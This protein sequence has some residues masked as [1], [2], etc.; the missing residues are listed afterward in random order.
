MDAA[1]PVTARLGGIASGAR[2]GPS[3]RAA[4]PAKGSGS[5][6]RPPA[7]LYVPGARR[8]NQRADKGQL[9]EESTALF[10]LEV[11][12]SAGIE[13]RSKGASIG[14]RQPRLFEWR[15]ATVV[16]HC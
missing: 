7:Q 1:V 3:T 13:V 6:K 11:E 16:Q 5:A 9:S 14:L 15:A 2:P 4:R 8:R 12:V 10:K